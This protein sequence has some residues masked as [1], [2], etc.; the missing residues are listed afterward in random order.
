MA[1]QMCV[2]G[3]SVQN[4]TEGK[5]KKI[6]LEEATLTETTKCFIQDFLLYQVIPY[7]RITQ[8]NLISQLAPLSV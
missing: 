8:Y 7:R 5:I 3:Y 1:I 4:R 2:R 6:K